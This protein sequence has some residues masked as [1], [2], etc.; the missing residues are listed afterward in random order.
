[1]SE[2]HPNVGRVTEAAKALD[3][4]IEVVEYPDGSR[5][6]PDAAAAGGCDVAQIV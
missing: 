3:L 2:Q 6:A 1:M 5:T 4:D